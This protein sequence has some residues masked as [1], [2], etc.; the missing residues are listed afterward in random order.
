MIHFGDP[1]EREPPLILIGEPE[2]RAGRMP[3]HRDTAA[4]LQASR[5]QF[6]QGRD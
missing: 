1:D 2:M 5:F 3:E 6:G 4:V